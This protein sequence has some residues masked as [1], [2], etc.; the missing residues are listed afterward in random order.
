[1]SHHT[2]KKRA[3]KLEKVRQWIKEGDLIGTVQ[4]KCVFHFNCTR[5]K[6]IEYI[7]EVTRE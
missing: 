3:L 5:E 7:A 2:Q 6:A 4:D 1:M